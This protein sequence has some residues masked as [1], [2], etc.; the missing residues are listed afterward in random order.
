MIE[1]T[2]AKIE[3]ALREAR[4]A[5]KTEI[6]AL[7]E[8]LKVEVQSERRSKDLLDKANEALKNAAAEFDAVH[9]K[10]GAIIGELSAMLAKIGI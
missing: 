9:P 1:E 7:L 4:V 6:V 10:L 5:N 2:L 3:S 8:K